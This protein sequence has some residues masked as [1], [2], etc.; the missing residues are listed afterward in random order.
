[1]NLTRLL[2]VIGLSK[3]IVEAVEL[4]IISALQTGQEQAM[5]WQSEPSSTPL[6]PQNQVPEGCVI[7]RNPSKSTS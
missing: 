7:R 1:M 6:Q 4:A 3:S 2:E 5:E